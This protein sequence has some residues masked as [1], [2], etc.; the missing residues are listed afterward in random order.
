MKL[1]ACSLFLFAGPGLCVVT[2]ILFAQDASSLPQPRAYSTVIPLRNVSPE[3]VQAGS[4]AATTIPLWNFSVT[5]PIDNNVYSGMMVG[6]S[7][8]YHGARITNIPA[9]I[10]PLIIK[11]SD[12][13][14]FDPTASDSTCSPA[15]TPLSLV[16]NSPLFV[17]LDI[18]MGTVDIGTAQYL[19]AF[20][21]GNFWTNVSVTENRYH[22]TLSPVTVLS[23][24]TVSVPKADGAVFSTTPY[25]G[26][27]GTI[28]V[29][30]ISWFDPY[31][32][33]TIIPSL[34]SQ[35]VGPT[36]FPLFVLKDVVMSVGASPS[37]P[38]NCCVLGYH[39]AFGSPTQ[40]YS[41]ADFD[42]TGIFSGVSD[43]TAMSHEIGEWMND[44]TGNNPTPA[45]GHT[46]QVSGCQ[47]NLEVGDPLSG[48]QFPALLASNGFTY[49]PQ[50][51]AFFS[52]FFRESPSLGVN[53]WYSDNGSFAQDA[54]AVCS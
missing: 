22:T 54:G 19:D 38:S 41:P 29:M 40:T 24:L 51:L 28:G 16:Q 25:G 20:Q 31:L 8:L 14:V 37:F 27:G 2:P 33:G 49:H 42:T 10:V 50:E 15:G 6:R 32:T 26:C 39:G 17:P 9:K 44:P 21:R 47:N 46:G 5:S 4:V 18:S 52:W 30:D 23:A 45:W 53:G 12:G 11:F 36:T 43:I 34:A 35:G 3:T 13:T 7:P 48:T 1:I